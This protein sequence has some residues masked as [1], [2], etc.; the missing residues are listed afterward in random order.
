MTEGW[1]EPLLGRIA[2]KREAVVCPVIDIIND[3]NF[4]FV[5]VILYWISEVVSS[6]IF[7]SFCGV[8]DEKHL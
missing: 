4:S 6:D 2:E 7:V 3:D 8:S 5:K 1:I